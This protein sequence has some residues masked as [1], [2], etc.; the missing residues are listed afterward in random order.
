MQEKSFSGALFH[1]NCP[2][3]RKGLV[4]KYP[5]WKIGRFTQMHEKCLH[6]GFRLEPEPGFYFGAMFV[7]YAFSVAIIVAVVLFLN[8]VTKPGMM[9][10][11]I[12]SIVMNLLLVPVN[13]RASRMLFLFLFGGAKYRFEK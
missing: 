8:I 9:D 11:I 6:C 13:F 3:C 7:S 12:W 2:Q 10:Y 5:F 1:G 4:F